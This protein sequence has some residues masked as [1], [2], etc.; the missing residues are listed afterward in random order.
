MAASKTKLAMCEDH[1]GGCLAWATLMLSCDIFIIN[2]LYATKT[3][4][5]GYNIEIH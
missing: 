5:K 4:F 2:V 1:K 3:R